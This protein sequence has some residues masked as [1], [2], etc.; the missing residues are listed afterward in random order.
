MNG[1]SPNRGLIT[2]IATRYEGVKVESR[3]M[4]FGSESHE[5][6]A[7]TLAAANSLFN[8]VPIYRSANFQK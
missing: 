7:I 2:W 4:F 8:P 3:A 1:W 5:S 6:R